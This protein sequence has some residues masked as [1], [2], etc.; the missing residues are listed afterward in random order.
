MIRATTPD[1]T[2]R[3]FGRLTV[4][5]RA[6]NNGDGQAQW[7][8]ECDCGRSVIRLAGYL[9]IAEKRG[10][11]Q[12]CG[13]WKNELAAERRRAAA[14]HGLTRATA[15]NRKLYDVWRQML[16]RCEDPRCQDFSSY[17]QRGIRVCDEWHDP[18]VF[19]A[20]CE[21]SGYAEGLTLERSK[22]DGNYEPDNCTWVPNKLQATNTRR[23]RTYRLGDREMCLSEWSRHL[24]IHVQTLLGRLR[25]GWSIERAFSETP[26][27]GKNQYA[28][29]TRP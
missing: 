18:F 27:L 16:R 26:Q 22:V 12:S 25:A 29:R 7:H 4:I 21:A 28:E 13:C 19:V 5:S 11:R 9:R 6:D 15:P 10:A 2:R 20:W 23:A 1:M 17:G 3:R 14:T 24:G 8:C